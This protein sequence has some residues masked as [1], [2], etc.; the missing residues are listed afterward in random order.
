VAT[1]RETITPAQ[2]A[3]F[4]TGLALMQIGVDALLSDERASFLMKTL[5]RRDTP[6]RSFSRRFY[7]SP[8]GPALRSDVFARDQLRFGPEALWLLQIPLLL[9]DSDTSAVFRRLE[10]GSLDTEIEKAIRGTGRIIGRILHGL[11]RATHDP[12]IVRRS[13]RDTRDPV[14][15]A[16]AEA[17]LERGTS[18]SEDS[19]VRRNASVTLI[20]LGGMLTYETFSTVEAKEVDIEDDESE[21]AIAGY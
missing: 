21:P 15:T 18:D 4:L 11:I 5:E 1:G 12:S 20:K 3:N 13:P 6:F 7:F 16:L 9:I 14:D 17:A 8:A 2:A 19:N 10:T